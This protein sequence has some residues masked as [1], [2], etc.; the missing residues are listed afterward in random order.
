MDS[1]WSQLLCATGT[2]VDVVDGGLLMLSSGSIETDGSQGD[3]SE[4][5]GSIADDVGSG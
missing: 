4:G 1:F 5:A 3:S 2:G